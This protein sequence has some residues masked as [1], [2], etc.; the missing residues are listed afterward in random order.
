MRPALAPGP[1]A[2]RGHVGSRADD[3]LRNLASKRSL[4]ERSGQRVGAADWR[5]VNQ[6]GASFVAGKKSPTGR[7][8][9]RA[10]FL[11]AIG[12]RQH[13][14]F[15]IRQNERLLVGGSFAGLQNLP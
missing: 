6:R 13:T 11:L 2:Q 14:L 7:R 4:C 5:T 3:A 1:K 12:D 9:I 15:F 8:A 10:F